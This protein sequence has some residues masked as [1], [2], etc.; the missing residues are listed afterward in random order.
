MSVK[1]LSTVVPVEYVPMPEPPPTIS[2]VLYRAW[3][4]M[5]HDFQ[6]MYRDIKK[7]PRLTPAPAPQVEPPPDYTKEHLFII[8]P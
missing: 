4:S 5:A 7:Q 8:Q 1:H 6:N 3:Q 2:Q